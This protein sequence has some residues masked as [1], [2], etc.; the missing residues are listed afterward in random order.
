MLL[1]YLLRKEFTLIRRNAFLPRFIIAYPV[2]VMLVF[3]WVA[4]LDVKDINLCIV[5]HDHSSF[6]RLLTQQ[7]PASGYFH[8]AAIAPGYE[9]AMEYIKRNQADVI[10]LIPPDFEKDLICGETTSVQIAPNS[11]NG[12]KGLFAANYLTQILSLFPHRLSGQQTPDTLIPL[13][14]YNP[15]LSYQSFI[16]PALIVILLTVIC[17]F[18]PALNLVAE[19]EQGTLEQ[20]HVTPLNTSLFLLS[21]LIPYWIIGLF[22]LSLA[23]VLAALCYRLIP[24]GSLLAIYLF[25]FLFILIVSAFGLLVANFSSSMQQAMF[26]IFFFTMVMLLLSGTFTPI[27][28]MPPWAQTLTYANPLRYFIDAMRALYLKGSPLSELYPQ[29]LALAALAALLIPAAFASY[30]KN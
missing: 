14:R 9:E 17:T 30:R 7:I 25:A 3:P 4:S 19:K 13:Y 26:V 5:D 10:L 24:A 15:H 12:T 2:V 20:L 8:L 1:K 18:L 28:S 27:H 6:S 29:L 11:V 21:K 23:L 22:V 16:I